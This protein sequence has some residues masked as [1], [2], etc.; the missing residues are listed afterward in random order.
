[1]AEYL[2][3]HQHSHSSGAA[4]S[5]RH[6]ATAEARKAAVRRGVRRSLAAPTAPR[7]ALILRLW[8]R[9]QQ[10]LDRHA[11]RHRQAQQTARHGAAV[12]SDESSM[13]QI[14][15][16]TWRRCS[17]TDGHYNIDSLAFQVFT[18]RGL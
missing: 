17:A 2:R 10:D 4:D 15:G 12:L 11:L 14:T 6:E 1:M 3:R 8:D 7:S 16:D 13:M 9:Q 18:L 5:T